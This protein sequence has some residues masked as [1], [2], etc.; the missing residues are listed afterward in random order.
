M[1]VTYL[2][3]LG[4]HDGDSPRESSHGERMYES[5]R[6]CHNRGAQKT[7]NWGMSLSYLVLTAFRR[8]QCAMYNV[9]P[10]LG[11]DH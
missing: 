2:D 8:N 11:N 5:N 6:L 7:R 3:Q 10:V 1:I 4:S 9:H